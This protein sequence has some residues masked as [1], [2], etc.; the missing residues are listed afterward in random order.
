MREPGPELAPWWADRGALLRFVADLVAAELTALRHERILPDGWS[1]ALSL[2]HD[3]GVDSLEL[4]QLAGALAEA[5]QMQ[6]SG[7]EDY[8]LARRTLDDWLDIATA[9]LQHWS[10]ELTFRTSGSSGEPKRC[11]HEL[12]LL[13][14]E[15]AAL[16]ALFPRRR[17][18]L[19]A[20][21]CHHI[22]GFLFGV[23]L[24][25]HLGLE[26]DQVLDV[27]GRLPSQ[28]ARHV[29][30]G[31]LVIGHPHAWQDALGAGAAFP[32]DVAGASSTAPCPD[33]VAERAEAAGLRLVQV[34]GAS[35]T[36]GLGWRASH[37]DSYRLMPYLDRAPDG[38]DALLRC[39]PDG[40]TTLLR[41]QD[42]LAWLGPDQ[43]MVGPRRD[44]AV[45]VGGT[46]VFPE[47]VRQVLLEHPM[48]EDAAVRLMRP[49]EGMRLKAFIVPRAGAGEGC[50]RERF[51]CELRAWI[52]ARLAAPER[53]KAITLGERIPRG[54]LDKPADWS[55]GP[56]NG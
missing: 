10:E 26:P 5:L 30:P 35:E 9:A 39:C 45:Q 55:I 2:Q 14:Q 53:P 46:N 34:Y 21:P 51:T 23:L 54:A 32:E 11:G 15:A 44:A 52:D 29:L 41:P 43:F 37:R 16:A 24:P 3:L 33:A 19:L 20:V 38:V 1:G 27:R 40:R 17:R 50:T 4:L 36:G 42:S 31:D 25:R 22:Y 48:V 47:R 49:D 28:L 7:V 8:L 18:L 6:R 13:E 12:V 56:M